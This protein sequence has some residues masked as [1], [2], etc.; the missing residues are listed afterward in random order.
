[1]GG[2]SL[3]ILR[4]FEKL[5]TCRG[6]PPFPGMAREAWFHGMLRNRHL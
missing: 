2:A 3:L 5:F 1:M 4:S 6:R